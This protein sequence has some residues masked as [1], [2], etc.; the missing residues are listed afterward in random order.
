M[1]AVHMLQVDQMY[2]GCMMDVCGMCMYVA[3]VLMMYA[4]CMLD[5]CL[6]LYWMYVTCLFDFVGCMLDVC[7]M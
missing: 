5:V 4:G 6:N 2:A 1:F 3:R 7:W